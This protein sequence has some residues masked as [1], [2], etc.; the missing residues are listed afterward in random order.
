MTK[1]TKIITTVGPQGISGLDG[2]NGPMGA[3][4]S[5]GLTGGKGATGPMGAIGATGPAGPAGSLIPDEIYMTYG[6]YTFIQLFGDPLLKEPS[7]MFPQTAFALSDQPETYLST[8][9]SIISPSSSR[10]SSNN[11]T[12]TNSEFTINEGG[13]YK[14]EFFANPIMALRPDSSWLTDGTLVTFLLVLEKETSL[15][16][17]TNPIALPGSVSYIARSSTQKASKILQLGIG[18]T[19][20]MKFKFIEAIYPGTIPAPS[21]YLTFH[22]LGLSVLKATNN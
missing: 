7:F 9:P 15:G 3:T 8:L 17:I 21:Q 14:V 5:H 13:M 18:D 1:C 6:N 10:I 2:P 19:L 22:T 20:R 12:I 4:G 11:V 16:V